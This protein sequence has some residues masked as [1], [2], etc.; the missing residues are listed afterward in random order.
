M[1]DAALVRLLTRE[2]GIQPLC[3]L[4]IK[5]VWGVVDVRGG[6]YIW[7][8]A[9]RHDGQRRLLELARFA[10]GIAPALTLAAPVFTRGGRML[11]GWDGQLGYLQPWL[12]G[13]HVLLSNP[14]E[15][16]SA[17]RTLLQLHELSQSWLSAL[18]SFVQR[19]GL[20]A[21]MTGKLRTLHSVWPQAEAAWPA[22]A[23]ARGLVFAM[24]GACPVGPAEPVT[25]VAFCHR[26]AA[27]HNLIWLSGQSKR[28]AS[29]AVQDPCA[30]RIA[31]IDF[32]R[33]GWD[34]PLV[35]VM[36][37][38][39]HSVY[40]APPGA[41][42]VRRWMDAYQQAAALS[43]S[44]EERAWRL[45]LFP[46]V[47]VRALAEWYGQGLPARGRLRVSAALHK[48]RQRWLAWQQDYRERFGAT[49][50][51]RVVARPWS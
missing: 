13:R 7:K 28:E 39:N 32:D 41:T 37:L 29:Q 38:F 2:Y 8:P 22:L 1:T 12:A 9:G 44:T 30:G 10:Q 46:D 26:D 48:E 51:R 3:I 24:A 15:R 33:A 6:R 49:Q 34:D 17:L 19:A 50:L 42:E 23:R 47:L 5:T 31:L 4:P 40:F 21:R 35:D 16:L 25:G 43:E 45:L 36:Q 18:P 27:P 20:A 11:S 14:D